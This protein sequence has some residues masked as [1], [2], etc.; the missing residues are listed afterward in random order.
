VAFLHLGELEA[1]DHATGLGRIVL[2]DR[3]LQ[4]F[5]QRLGLAELAP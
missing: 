5:A 2:V 3:R 4:P 1:C